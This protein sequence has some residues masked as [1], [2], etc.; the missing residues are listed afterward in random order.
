M[1]FLYKLPSDIVDIIYEYDGRYEENYSM[2]IDEIHR[3]ISDQRIILSSIKPF[4]TTHSVMWRSMEKPF[5]VFMMNRI[6]RRR[7]FTI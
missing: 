6:R 2:C 3:A 7:V 4:K 1:S 5:Y